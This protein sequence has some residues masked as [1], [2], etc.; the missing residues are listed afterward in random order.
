M[1]VAVRQRLP[2]EIPAIVLLPDHPHCIWTLPPDDHDFP[3]RWRRLMVKA[4]QR[5]A[6]RNRRST[7]KFPH[8]NPL[9]LLAAY[10]TIAFI[11]GPLRRYRRR[12]KGMC[13]KCGYD[14]TGNVS[15]TFPECGRE[16]GVLLSRDG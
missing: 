1:F 13:I 7:V 10:A 3:Q 15:G 9:V 16:V 5:P 4:G 2:F 14:L 6:L 12:R 8:W 11:R